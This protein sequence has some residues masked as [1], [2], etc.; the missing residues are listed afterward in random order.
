MYTTA[1]SHAAFDK[2]VSALITNRW[3]FSEEKSL[4][5]IMI[6]NSGKEACL[7]LVSYRRI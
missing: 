6:R 2:H 5:S 4:P 7:K 3:P 1:L